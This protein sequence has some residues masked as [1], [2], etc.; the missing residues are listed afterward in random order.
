M[1]LEQ[2]TDGQGPNPG[3]ARPPDLPPSERKLIVA[4]RRKIREDGS[5]VEFK[6]DRNGDLIAVEKVL[7][8]ASDFT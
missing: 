4:M 7:H 5:R 1:G 6:E 3:Q 2:I 8:R